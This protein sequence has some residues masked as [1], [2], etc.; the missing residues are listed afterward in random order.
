MRHQP[1]QIHLASLLMIEGFAAFVIVLFGQFLLNYI[2]F[3]ITDIRY[4]A[5]LGAF[6]LF[7]VPTIFSGAI[8]PY[9]YRLNIT[10]IESSGMRAGSLSFVG[11]AGSATGT[12]ATSF[13]LVLY[14]E[15]HHIM[16]TMMCISITIWLIICIQTFYGRVR[17]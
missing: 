3:L 2:S 4:S 11:T 17:S 14:F 10:D 1:M 8:L 13:Y 6:I 5:L 16:L 7:G 15:I 9:A 12:L